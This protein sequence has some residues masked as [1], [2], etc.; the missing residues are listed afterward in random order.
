M[1]SSIAHQLA[2]WSERDPADLSE[3]DV[4]NHFIFLRVEHGYSPQ[5]I[6]Q[7]RTSTS[8]FYLGMLSREWSLFSTIKTKDP[9]RG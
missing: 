8:K 1:S 5:S 6:R 3:E 2:R 9:E 7:A 4:R